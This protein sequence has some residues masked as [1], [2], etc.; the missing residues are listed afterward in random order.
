MTIGVNHVRRIAIRRFRWAL[1][2]GPPARRRQQRWEPAQG[3]EILGIG[4]IYRLEPAT[5]AQDVTSLGDRYRGG[6]HL[7]TGDGPPAEGRGHT[8][9][10]SPSTGL[11]S[12]MDSRE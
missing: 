4:D 3:T 6:A 5:G 9:A 11:R 1:H 8:G 2:A 12:S 10:R 7:T